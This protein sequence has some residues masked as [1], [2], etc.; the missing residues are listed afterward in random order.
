[1]GGLIDQ[2]AQ[3][4]LQ[5]QR[6]C[7]RPLHKE[8]AEA[9]FAFTSDAATCQFLR[10]GPHSDIDQVRAFIDRALE[11][12]KNANDIHWGVCVNGEPGIIGAVHIYQIDLERGQAD[13]SYILNPQ[14]TGKGYMTECVSAIIQACIESLSLRRVYA[15]F[16]E[17]NDASMH[18]M[19][20]CGMAPDPSTPPWETLIKGTSLKTY[21]Y[22]YPA[23]P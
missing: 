19:S 18:V 21:R 12:R 17:G 10:W 11:N 6:L 1:M 7:L 14:Y 8:D 20:R 23:T 3:R 2:L 16:V 9:M 22:V 5:T 15:D 13:V 4:G